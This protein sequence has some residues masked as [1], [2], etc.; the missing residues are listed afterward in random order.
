MATSK[1]ILIQKAVQN[2]AHDNPSFRNRWISATS[3]QKVLQLWY[4]SNNSLTVTKAT[5][6]HAKGKID[7]NI[8]NQ[9]INI[10]QGFTEE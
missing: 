3:L 7:S 1:V 4:K 8:D 6:S 2:I 5:L 10:I 9:N